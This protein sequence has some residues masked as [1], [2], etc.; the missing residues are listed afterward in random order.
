MFLFFS[1]TGGCAMFGHSCYGGHGKRS[2]QAPVQEPAVRYW[3]GTTD[4]E[5]QINDV[6]NKYYQ[7]KRSPLIWKKLDVRPKV[8]E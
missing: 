7:M 4:E 3:P 5:A 8:P 6:I 2:F 1:G